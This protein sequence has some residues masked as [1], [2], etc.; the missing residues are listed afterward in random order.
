MAQEILVDH[1]SYP[2]PRYRQN[3]HLYRP[4]GLG[5]SNLGSLLMSA[6]HRLRF[7]TP[8]AASCGAVTALLHGAGNLHERRDGR[9]GRPVRCVRK[10][11]RAML[12]VMQMHR[13]AVEHINRELPAVLCKTP[14]A[15]PGT[16][17]CRR[18]AYTASATPRPRCSP[19]PARSA[20]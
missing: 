6:G 4:L 2:T 19:P 11:S 10:E 16:S 13:D 8:A 18:A 15:V 12:D 20:S 1:A 5:Y 14:P 7:A 17:A 9:S 3:S